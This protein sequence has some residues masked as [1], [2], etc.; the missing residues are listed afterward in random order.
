VSSHTYPRR[1]PDSAFRPVG[2]EGG[3][4]VLSGK[5]EVK[6]LNPVAIKVFGLLDGEHSQEQIAQAVVEEYEVS[7][8]EALRDVK[9]FIEELRCHGMLAEA[10]E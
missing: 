10:E 9:S 2:D 6:V 8:E 7:E 1:H 4:V 5:S 3:L